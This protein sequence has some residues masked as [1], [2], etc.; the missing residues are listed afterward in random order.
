VDV[1]RECIQ[2]FPDWVDNE[3]YAYNNKHSLRSNTKSYG[4]KIHYIDSQNSETTAP[5]GREVYHLQFSLQVASPETFGYAL[6]FSILAPST[7]MFF[8]VIGTGTEWTV[9]FS[10]FLSKS[11]LFKDPGML[12][13]LIYLSNE[14]TE[15]KITFDVSYT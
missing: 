6:V 11:L 4:S 8:G 5:N 12:W 15:L 13:E 1:I 9:G 7:F 14:N 2:N 10:Y 3:I